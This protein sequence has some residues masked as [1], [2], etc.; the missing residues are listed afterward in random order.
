MNGDDT[1]DW[2]E[3]GHGA[4]YVREPLFDPTDETLDDTARTGWTLYDEQHH[5]SNADGDGS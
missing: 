5:T 2:V 4:T 3:Y 1:T